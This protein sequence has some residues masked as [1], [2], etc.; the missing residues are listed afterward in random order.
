MNIYE[1][2]N[3]IDNE[4]EKACEQYNREDR[5]EQIINGTFDIYNN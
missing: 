2:M 1:R 3:I 4:K 5:E